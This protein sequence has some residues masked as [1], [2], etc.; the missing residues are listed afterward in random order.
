MIWSVGAEVEA[1]RGFCIPRRR[2]HPVSRVRSERKAIGT[3]TSAPAQCQM[4]L[5][6]P[7]GAEE[8]IPGA[9]SPLQVES[10]SAPKRKPGQ[11]V[12]QAPR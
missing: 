12:T 4:S 8:M 6:D 10:A 9:E 2:S 7:I 1:G 5:S 11:T 3:K